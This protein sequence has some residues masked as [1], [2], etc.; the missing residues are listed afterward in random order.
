MAD[1]EAQGMEARSVTSS[2]IE[3]LFA[4]QLR[5]NKIPFEREVCLIP[6][7]KFRFDFVFR[8]QHLAAECDGGIWINGRHSRGS[9]IERDAE[10]YSLAAALGYRVARVT[11]SMVL[12][13]AAL[14]L[15]E[16]A[17]SWGDEPTA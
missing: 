15:I 16:Q 10:K 17:L 12:S 4:W 9:G 14:S 6:G 11:A 3:E 8:D 2:E 1:R 7:R 5:A 13:G